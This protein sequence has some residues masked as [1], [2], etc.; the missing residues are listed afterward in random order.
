MQTFKQ[1]QHFPTAILI[2]S[3]KVGIST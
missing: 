3:H 2:D 1:S